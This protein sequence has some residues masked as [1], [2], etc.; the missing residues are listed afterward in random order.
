MSDEDNDKL[1]LIVVT[2]AGGIVQDVAVHGCVRV[3]IHDRYD[4]TDRDCAKFT[5]DKGN[6]PLLLSQLA[7][8]TSPKPQGRRSSRP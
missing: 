7:L 1:P 3:C 8:W 5:T 2:M 4:V 6:E